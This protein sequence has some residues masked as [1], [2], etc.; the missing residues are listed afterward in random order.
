[1]NALSPPRTKLFVLL[2][3][4]LAAAPALSASAEANHIILS[5]DVSGSMSAKYMG[6]HMAEL[7]RRFLLELLFE[8]GP[9]LEA[10]PHQDEYA[11]EKNV[12]G[13]FRGAP[14]VQDDALLSMF[15]F[16][17]GVSIAAQR[18]PASREAVERFLP[19]Q[20]RAQ[21]TDMRAAIEA[22]AQTLYDPELDDNAYWVII[23]D[24]KDDPQNP[25]NWV[26]IEGIVTKRSLNLVYGLSVFAPAQKARDLHQRWAAGDA[27][28]VR[29]FGKAGPPDRA[30]I[31][32][33]EV[34]KKVSEEPGKPG[35]L[36][37]PVH[38]TC[39]AHGGTLELRWYPGE[40]DA[41][42]DGE[43]PGV[44]EGEAA[45]AYEIELSRDGA[46][47][48]ALPGS[49][50]AKGEY[51]YGVALESLSEPKGFVRATAVAGGERSPSQAVEYNLG[52][53]GPLPSV[54]QGVEALYDAASGT[55]TVSWRQPT[56]EGLAVRVQRSADNGSTWESL[57][58][59][60][61]VPSAPGSWQTGALQ[62]GDLVR[63]FSVSEAGQSP[64]HSRPVRVRDAAG[65]GSGL[66]LLLVL[67]ALLI[68]VAVVV[69]LKW[70]RAI[71]FELYWDEQKDA[72]GRAQR[73]SCVLRKHERL[74]FAATAEEDEA[75]VSWWREVDAPNDYLVNRGRAIYHVRL[76]EDDEDEREIDELMED[77]DPFQVK[78]RNGRE[79]TLIFQEA[80]GGESD[81]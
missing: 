7:I 79:T 47:W 73:K 3:L 76:S 44:L 64:K 20:F 33:I 48:Q 57:N 72:E 71:A 10:Y 11:V 56:D 23:S 46:A 67:L 61:P 51:P 42:R 45:E 55:T 37:P 6:E 29:A 34:S 75:V 25:S 21:N 39:E 16:G 54:P 74:E 52:G 63:L 17:T 69:W 70:P 81:V 68:A 18:V 12:S 13:Q 14:L 38:L 41:A 60:Q 40:W 4:C 8:S 59:D 78:R 19:T 35:T 5:Y 31:H 27:G 50:P 77:G 65:D 1:M 15:T 53:G 32:V 24:G 36:R 58:A 62:K 26:G 49:V 9:A 30:V 2:L 43:A 28:L 66:W 80:E 22:A